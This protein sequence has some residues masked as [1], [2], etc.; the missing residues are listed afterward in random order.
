MGHED[1]K[2][3]T[4]KEKDCEEDE[5]KDDE[6]AKETDKERAKEVTENADAKARQQEE[7][8][9]AKQLVTKR[10]RTL[11]KH[12]S[13]EVEQPRKFNKFDLIGRGAASDA[14]LEMPPA[15]GHGESTF[16]L[17]PRAKVNRQEALQLQLQECVSQQDFIG[18]EA[19]KQMLWKLQLQCDADSLQDQGVEVADREQNILANERG[20]KRGRILSKH[21]S[22]ADAPPKKVNRPGADIKK[23]AR[24]TPAPESHPLQK[25]HGYS[26]ANLAAAESDHALA[27]VTPN[28]SHAPAPL[29]TSA[30]RSATKEMAQESRRP[31]KRAGEDC[32]ALAA[33]KQEKVRTQARP[34]NI[35][36]DAQTE[37]HGRSEA[38]GH[39]SLAATGP[40]VTSAILGRGVAVRHVAED[41]EE[42]EKRHAQ[43]RRVKDQLKKCLEDED[44][45]G[46]ASVKENIAA[47]MSAEPFARGEVAKRVEKEDEED[48][49]RQAELRRAQ[50][51]LNK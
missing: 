46:A 44:Y 3:Q 16:A 27:P 26:K 41:D 29:A 10:N 13:H 15:T 14:V 40:A 5:E 33:S 25:G 17:S 32:H 2:Q 6:D 31:R 43:L 23:E 7:P 45:M 19:C 35:T 28:K 37:G 30:C 36:A 51:Q 48:E 21:P 39:G 8:E 24:T 50:D 11:E 20:A 9:G 34:W 42:E 22:A 18:A 49:K 1:Q 12:T 4:Q 38:T 47:I